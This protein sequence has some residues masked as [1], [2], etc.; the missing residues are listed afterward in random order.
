MVGGFQFLGQMTESERTL[1]GDSAQR[2]RP[3]AEAQTAALA[4][5]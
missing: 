5:A 2:Q 3:T 1:A 4:I